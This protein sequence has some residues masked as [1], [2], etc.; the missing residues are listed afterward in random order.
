MSNEARLDAPLTQKRRR[1]GADGAVSALDKL[2]DALCQLT[3]AIE[4]ALAE[5]AR[6]SGTTPD[7]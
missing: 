7:E 5:R 1:P 4:Q 6:E 2:L 3:T